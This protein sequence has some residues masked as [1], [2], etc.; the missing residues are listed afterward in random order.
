MAGNSVNGARPVAGLF[1][2][3]AALH[4]GVAAIAQ[5]HGLGGAPAQRYDNGSLPVYA[6]GAQH[7]LKLYPAHEQA[8]IRS[9][10]AD[11]LRAVVTQTLIKKKEGGRIAALDGGVADIIGSVLTFSDSDVLHERGSGRT[12]DLSAVLQQPLGC[13]GFDSITVAPVPLL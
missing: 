7:V 1:A 12:M 5:R 13:F 6:L 11:V 4:S 8:Q 9:V 2:D 3:D 10:L